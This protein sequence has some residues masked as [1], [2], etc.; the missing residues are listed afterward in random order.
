MHVSFNFHPDDE[1]GTRF[2]IPLK[3]P[4]PHAV[5]NDKM[6]TAAILMWKPDARVF[7]Y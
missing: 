2:R 6:A 5:S 3:L 7:M 4:V 1:R